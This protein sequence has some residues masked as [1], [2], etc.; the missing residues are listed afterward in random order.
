MKRIATVIAF[1]GLA[2][3]GSTV[4]A[5]SE[6]VKMTDSQM[7]NI[8]G[9]QLVNVVLVDVVD[10]RNVTVKAAVPVNAAVAAN[11]LGSGDAVAV[12]TQ[13]VRIRQ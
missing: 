4:F 13:R 3:A 2:T 11:V 10:V 12:S 6:P 1:F 5:G 7:D 8:A 9:G